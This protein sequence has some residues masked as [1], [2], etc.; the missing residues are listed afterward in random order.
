MVHQILPRPSYLDTCIFLKVVGDRKVWKSKD[1]KRLYTWDSLHGEIEVFD[2]HGRHMGS[3]HALTG[4]IFKSAV[5]GRR[6]DV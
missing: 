1:G 2:R 5:K 6:L 4:V 3:A